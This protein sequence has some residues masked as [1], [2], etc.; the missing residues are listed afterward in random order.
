MRV[1]PVQS[2]ETAR[3]RQRWHPRDGS[4]PRKDT[5]MTRFVPKSGDPSKPSAGPYPPRRRPRLDSLPRLRKELV[6][7][8][9]EAKAG[10]LDPQHAT[11]LGWLL[12][13]AS[14]IIEG[15]ELEVRLAAV[16]KRLA[17]EDKDR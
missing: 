16:E 8:Y 15:G 1:L 4:S 17:R 14:K 3:Q 10:D 6:A 11:R 2:G 5:E 9:H 12:V 7:L 13:A